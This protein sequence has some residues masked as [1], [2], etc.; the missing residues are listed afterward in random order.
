MTTRRQFGNR[1][2][3][4]WKV[5]LSAVAVSVL[6]LRTPLAAQHSPA[7]SQI[8][9]A[10]VTIIDVIRGV[11]NADMTVLLA[12]GRIEEIFK[13]ADRK[14]PPTAH[15][16][17]ASGKFLI[18]GLWDM[19]VHIQDAPE[20]FAPLY[21]AHGIT[22]IRDMRMELGSLIELRSK[23]ARGELFAPRLIA[24]GPALDDPPP[25][26]PVPIKMRI[27]TATQAREA[28]AT[29]K[30]NRVDFIKVHNF[31]P[32][33]AFFAIAEKTKEQQLTFVGHVPLSV[34]IREAVEA[35]QRSIEHLSEFRVVEECSDPAKRH[36]LI[37]LFKKHDT[38]HTPTLVTLRLLGSGWKADEG[39][40][41]YVPS[42]V[43]KFWKLTDS[44]L[45]QMTAEQKTAMSRGYRDALPLVGEFQRK[46]IGILTGTDSP[47]MPGIVPG[48]SL[49]DELELMVEAGLT[50]VQA[51]QTATVY[52]ARFLGRLGELGTL[53]QGKLADLVLLDANPLND[54]R[55]VGK[56]NAVIVQGRILDRAR[57]DIMLDEAKKSAREH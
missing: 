11:A 17:D 4:R 50:P 54:V 22:G 31:T 41:L 9:L 21:L 16:I 15:V 8:A 23:I 56:I 2:L 51:L 43:K 53:E 47:V 10:H 5:I 26:W 45:Q 18:P 28:V 57:L 37:E 36:D 32:R 39:R 1:T 52:P 33:E 40:D 6:C 12:D 7:P 20:V 35:G 48:F 38:W 44:M 27:K 14:S 49:H 42:S 29:L 24:S 19:H 3:K 13:A 30:S 55:N 46:G 25:E 34:T